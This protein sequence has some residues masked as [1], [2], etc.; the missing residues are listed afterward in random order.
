MA[1]APLPVIASTGGGRLSIIHQYLRLAVYWVIHHEALYYY[2]QPITIH[3][4][5]EEPLSLRFDSLQ[6]V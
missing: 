4:V 6:L 3:L 5:V 2:T 1:W